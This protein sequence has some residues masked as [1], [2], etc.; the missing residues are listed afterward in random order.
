VKDKKIQAVEELVARDDAAVSI[1]SPKKKSPVLREIF[2]WLKALTL[3][4]VFVF[5]MRN[6]VIV[7]ATVPTASMNPTIPTEARII[8]SRLSYIFS[9]PERFD[10]VAFESPDGTKTSYVKRIIGLPGEIVEII[11]GQV[12]INES[13][14]PLDEWYLLEPPAWISLTPQ[15]FYVPEGHF[16]VMGDHRNNSRDSRGLGGD[17]WENLFIPLENILGRIIIVYFPNISFVR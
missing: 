17:P 16:F 4:F 8:G 5:F 10:V 11:D 2:L 3:G 14:M 13:D 1:Y 7:Q 9:E 12:F 6:V 15:R